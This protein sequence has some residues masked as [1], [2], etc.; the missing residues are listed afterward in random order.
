MRQAS[1]I[2]AIAVTLTVAIGGTAFAQSVGTWK[3]NVAKST[4]HQG[5]APKSLTVKYEAA[6]AGVKAT[7]D[8]VSADNSVIHYAYTANYDGKENFVIGHPYGDMAARTR[9]NARTT[10]IV[11]KKGGKITTTQALVTSGDGKTLTIT[12]A[13]TDAQGQNV[14]SIGVYDKQ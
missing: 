13:G 2:T 7:V 1:L 10:K 9:V 11:M 5:Q 12:T 8:W 14:D 3:L 6:G 4:Y